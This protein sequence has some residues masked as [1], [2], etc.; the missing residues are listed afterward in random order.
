MKKIKNK[1]L[2]QI[3]K[4]MRQNGLST[5]DV[6]QYVQLRMM[7]KSLLKSTSEFDLLCEVDGKKV[8]LP[9]EKRHLGKPIAI[10]PFPNEPEYIELDEVEHKKR[11]DGESDKN[12]FVDERIFRERISEVVDRLN[13]CLKK[14]NK[15]L[16]KEFYVAS[17]SYTQGCG[18][19]ISFDSNN[20]HCGG[21]QSD[22]LRY[23]GRFNDKCQK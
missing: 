8:R 15:P 16:L 14:L 18:W 20:D 5:D 12:R 7:H 21:Y 13:V 1:K 9:F 6:L 3:Y 17:S 19:I 23:M 10:F 4:I 11:T 2:A 22:K